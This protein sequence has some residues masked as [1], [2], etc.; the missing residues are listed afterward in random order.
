MTECFGRRRKLQRSGQLLLYVILML[1][2][3]Y[4]SMTGKCVYL[5][6]LLFAEHRDLSSVVNKIVYCWYR[7]LLS[8]S[9]VPDSFLVKTCMRLSVGS[10]CTPFV[11]YQIPDVHWKVKFAVPQSTIPFINDGFGGKGTS[12]NSR[13]NTGLWSEERSSRLNIV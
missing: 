13:T 7:V 12:W 5:R 11:G 1:W 9:N 8:C 3:N 10:P 6:I 4:V 2:V